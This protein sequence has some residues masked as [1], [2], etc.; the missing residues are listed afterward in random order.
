M[1]CDKV[2]HDIRP[3]I[4]KIRL[5]IMEN[6]HMPARNQVISYIEDNNINFPFP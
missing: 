5:F 6:E 3:L 2:K 4:L 1:K